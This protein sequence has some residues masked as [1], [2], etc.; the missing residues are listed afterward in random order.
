[1]C[2]KIETNVFLDME[3]LEVV[4]DSCPLP[5]FENPPKSNSELSVMPVSCEN[6]AMLGCG[7]LERKIVWNSAYASEQERK[8]PHY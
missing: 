2:A 6:G 5:Q 8:L 1:M 4:M 7:P 3:D